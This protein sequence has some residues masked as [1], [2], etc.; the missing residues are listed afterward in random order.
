MILFIDD[1]SEGILV[2]FRVI[3]NRFGVLCDFLTHLA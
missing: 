1:Y 3:R 2:D